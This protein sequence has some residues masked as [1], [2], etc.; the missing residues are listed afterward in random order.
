[1]FRKIIQILTISIIFISF[2]RYLYAENLFYP[3]DARDITG[4]WQESV[5]EQD[6]V[7]K[8]ASLKTKGKIQLNIPEDGFYQLCIELY[9]NWHK[10]CPFIY[11]NTRDSQGKTFSDFLFS[12]KR[13]YLPENS[14]RW[15]MRALSANPFWFLHKGELNIEFW[16]ES[17]Q[18][19]WDKQ[20]KEIEGEFYIKRFILVKVDMLEK[21]DKNF[22]T[23]NLE[24]TEDF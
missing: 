14:G 16:L 22:Q 15:E 5:I 12:E 4:K 21:S 10:F 13:W 23:K 24:K 18:S 1:M 9:H 2:N 20:D 8:T 11:F 6:E 7:I 17:K 3:F 19:C